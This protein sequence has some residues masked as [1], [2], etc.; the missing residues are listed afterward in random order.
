MLITA[1]ILANLLEVLYVLAIDWQESGEGKAQSDTA[2]ELKQLAPR[3]LRNWKQA[4]PA[5]EPAIKSAISGQNKV[6]SLVSLGQEL[7][8]QFQL[9]RKN[10]DFTAQE[11]DV[12]NALGA[13]MRT[14]SENAMKKLVK[15]ANITQSVWVAQK[16]R[17]DV[18]SQGQ[19][20]GALRKLVKKMAGRDD[21][22]LTLEESKVARE[23]YPEVY[24]EY[25][26]LSRAFNQVWKDAL[27]NYVRQ[28]K[29]RLVPYQDVLDFMKA[30]GIQNKLPLGFTGLMD[31]QGK[32]YTRDGDSIDGVPNAL[33][34]PT[35]K[36][37][38]KYGPE[39]PWVFMAV[40]ADGSAPTY[41]Y[42]SDFKKSQAKSKFTKV[43]DL[44]AR[45]PQMRAKWFMNVK[46]FNQEN[47]TSVAS[48]ILELLYQYSAR[49][50]TTG[51]STYGC[52]TLLVKHL[53]KEPN[54]DYVI[55]YLGKDSV[56][57]KHVVRASDPEQRFLVVALDQ[58][59]ANKGPKDKVFT[60]TSKT[61]RPKLVGPVAVNKLFKELAGTSEITVHKLRTYRGTKL[62]QELADEMIPKLQPKVEKL[63]QK[64]PRLAEKLVLEEFKKIAEQV[65][66]LLN[67]VRRGAA[68]AKVT[69]VTAI[70]NY[71]DPQCSIT[72][73]RNLDTRPPKMLEKFDV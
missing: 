63:A 18:G 65:G 55:R 27:V 9:F 62:F 39:S 20:E 72:F 73:F 57:T 33:T 52:G 40:K 16:L 30:N 48:V 32:L 23:A 54:G 34:S 38:P 59:V 3:A 58:L 50:G 56:P 29:K 36:M 69:G 4:L 68:G 41:F 45:I 31:D 47:V 71:I 24:K 17:P 53:K 26:Q 12:L 44:T 61:G 64:N 22:S 11:L 35:V 14:D 49:V 15:L 8:D 43:K 19:S 1:S 46:K 70:A 7:K 2:A 10:H 25:L 28:T 37:N 42:T 66:K 51:N 21:V 5:L 67:H 6:E 60:S 13:Y